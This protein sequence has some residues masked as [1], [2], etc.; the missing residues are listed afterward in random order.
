MRSLSTDLSLG[1]QTSYAELL[2]MVRSVEGTRFGNL[3][4]SFH[5]RQI[6][7]KGYLYFNFRDIDGRGCS[8]YV[9]PENSRAQHLMEEFE[10]S[11]RVQRLSALS[12]RAQACS[13]LGCSSL[14]TKHFRVVQKLAK[15]GFF[16]AGGV[17]V[18]AQAFVTMGNMLGL[19]WES[20][21]TAMELGFTDAELGISI[22]LPTDFDIPDRDAITSLEEGLLP[23]RG[24]PYQRATMGSDR[25]AAEG[26]IRFITPNVDHSR[27]LSAPSFGI[28]QGLATF[29]GL[30]L[31]EAVNGVAFA[32][33]GAC[34]VNH[35]EPARLAVHDLLVYGDSAIHRQTK[36]NR[37]LVQSAAL[38]EWHMDQQ[39]I[40]QFREVW[41]DALARG[42]GWHESAKHGR[43]A[44]LETYPALAKAFE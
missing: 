43:Q 36:S 30:L 26:R 2:D 17:L 13:A 28:D 21:A 5:R 37:L 34:L 24:S 39:R 41:R 16:R 32:K 3:R 27:V 44:L 29:T 15:R 8:V 10:Q 20:S 38:I 14:S 12:Q 33:P 11:A 31:E 18:G 9:G 25:F 6:K 4:G 35:P 1:A 7:G 22:A 40:T 42:T 19:C 23:S